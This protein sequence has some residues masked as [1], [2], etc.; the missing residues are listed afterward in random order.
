[1]DDSLRTGGVRRA[2][3]L[4]DVRGDRRVHVSYE[5]NAVRVLS[6]TTIDQLSDAHTSPF[7]AGFV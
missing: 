1:L 4:A 7:S 2:A 3:A 6:D 5:I